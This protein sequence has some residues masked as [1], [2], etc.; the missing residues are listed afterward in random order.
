AAR[1]VTAAHVPHVRLRLAEHLLGGVLLREHH[2]IDTLEGQQA[3]RAVRLRHDR[4]VRTF[5]APHGIVG[6]DAHDEAVAEFPRAGEGSRVP[7]M[8][9]V[10]AAA[11]GDDG[12]PGSTNLPDHVLRGGD[13]GANGNESGDRKSTRL[14]SSHVSISYAV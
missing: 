3:L 12:P 14:N 6:I 11:G 2:R 10:E 4:P 8:H 1:V 7:G 5:E 13:P 9:E